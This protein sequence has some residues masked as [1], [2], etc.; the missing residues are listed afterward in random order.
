MPN[1]QNP[2]ST[3]EEPVLVSVAKTL[4]TAAGKIAALAGVTSDTPPKATS[5]KKGKFVAKNA[6]RLPRKLKKAK[7]KAA[8]M[9]KGSSQ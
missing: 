2:S 1:P 6:P 7:K 4:G 9:Q 8:E 3:V 5:E